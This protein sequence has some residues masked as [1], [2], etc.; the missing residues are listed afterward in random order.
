MKVLKIIY[1]II[2]FILFSPIIIMSWIFCI[3]KFKELIKAIKGE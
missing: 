3:E 2:F 1:Y